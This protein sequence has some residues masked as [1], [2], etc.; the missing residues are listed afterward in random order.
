MK[1]ITTVL[2][3]IILFQSCSEKSNTDT[4]IDLIKKVET[5]DMGLAI[6]NYA[7]WFL[8]LHTYWSY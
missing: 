5:G 2:F 1:N 7:K 3:I 6:L 8:S 4:K